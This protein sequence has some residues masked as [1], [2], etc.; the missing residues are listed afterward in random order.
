ML[1]RSGLKLVIVVLDNRG[2]GCISRLQ[3]AT[4]GAAFNN[5]LADS[6]PAGAP[7][8]DFA[9]HAA[10]LGAE[11]EKVGDV[12]ALAAALERA[13]AASRTYVIVIDT[14]PHAATHA[15]GAWWDVA[16][17]EVSQR[18]SVRAARAEYETRRK[19]RWEGR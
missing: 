17:P 8:I 6:R 12:G 9:A 10:A 13:R 3:R 18:D 4:G 11:S 14:D 5:L 7:P 2:F 19:A 1:F 15:G 16:V